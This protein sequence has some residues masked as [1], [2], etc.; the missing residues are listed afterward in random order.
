MS[1]T[2][3][4]SRSALVSWQSCQRRRWFEYEILNS[5]GSRGLEPRSLSL[6][7]ETGS[8]CHEIAGGLLAGGDALVVI[9][10]AISGYMS[11]VCARGLDIGI[12]P[13]EVQTSPV[14]EEQCALIEAFGWSFLRVRLPAIL[15]EYEVLS[16][17]EEIPLEVSDGVVMQTRADAVLRR[18]SDSRLFV[19]NL[20]TVSSPDDRWRAQWEVDMQ[21]MTEP[22]AVERKLGEKVHGVIIDGFIKGVRVGVDDRL[23]ECR[24]DKVATQEIQRSRLLY[25]YSCPGDSNVP[26]LYDFAGTTKKGWSK[27]RTWQEG[28]VGKPSWMSPIQYWIGWLPEEEVAACFVNEKSEKPLLPVVRNDEHVRRKL[29]QIMATEHQIRSGRN[30]VEDGSTVSSREDKLDGCFPQNERSCVYPTRCPFYKACWEPIG[31]LEQSGFYVPRVANHP[32]I[33]ASTEEL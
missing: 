29:V 5:A 28:F 6:P 19:Y 14:V 9:E 21:L 11:L 26:T 3:I 16:V 7:M 33:T 31:E 32:L 15:A 23:V 18:R 24:G 13:D 27:F 4:T 20:K 2:I 25:G 22:L 1:D 30:M 8:G 10:R 12:E 17:E